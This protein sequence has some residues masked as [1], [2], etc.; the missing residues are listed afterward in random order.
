M[1]LL[2]APHELGRAEAAVAFADDGNGRV[3]KL[4]F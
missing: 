3:P 1:G 2:Q 4:V